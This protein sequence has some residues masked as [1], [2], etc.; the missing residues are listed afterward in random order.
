MEHFADVSKMVKIGKGGNIFP[1]EKYYLSVPEREDCREA[2]RE[3]MR[4]IQNSSWKK[5]SSK[6]LYTLRSY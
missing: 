1:L 6:H 2:L 3:V 4:L 5:E